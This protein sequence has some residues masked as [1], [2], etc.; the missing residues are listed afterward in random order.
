MSN[1]EASVGAKA[2]DNLGLNGVKC[3]IDGND[4]VYAKDWAVLLHNIQ[5][6]DDGMSEIIVNICEDYHR[7]YGCGIK[8]MLAMVYL[9]SHSAHNLIQQNVPLYCVIKLMREAIHDCIE[10]INT[11]TIPFKLI[12]SN[13]NLKVDSINGDNP[14][15]TPKEGTTYKDKSVA[16]KGDS[17]YV[18]LNEKAINEKE[19]KFLVKE[20]FEIQDGVGCNVSSDFLDVP[21]QFKTPSE[22]MQNVQNDRSEMKKFNDNEDI[23]NCKPVL[24]EM[25]TLK[26]QEELISD[27]EDISWFF[28]NS[29]NPLTSEGSCEI[30]ETHIEKMRK[31]SFYQ[32]DGNFSMLTSSGKCQYDS[33]FEDCFDDDDEEE[34]KEHGED[35]LDSCFNS[36]PESDIPTKYEILE[37]H[38]ISKS[39]K[40]FQIRALD[41]SLK[42][43]QS[44][45]N[46]EKNDDSIGNHLKTN[47]LEL[48]EEDK[49]TRNCS[50]EDQDKVDNPYIETQYNS[51]KTS[52]DMKRI[53][54]V[55]NL[56]METECN[57]SK[58]SSD[59]KRID[60]LLHGLSLRQPSSLK[61]AK[62]VL[63]SSR[64]FKTNGQLSLNYQPDAHTESAYNL[65][66]ESNQID[67][68][69][70][71]SSCHLKT[72]KANKKH[73]TK[74]I[75]DK[76]LNL[77]K[78]ND[79]PTN[80]S[81]ILEKQPCLE[82][83]QST[84][85]KKSQFVNMTFKP[86]EDEYK[87]TRAR[88]CIEALGRGLSR[89]SNMMK[90]AVDCLRKQISE[91]YKTFHTRLLNSCLLI[92]PNPDF[93]RLVNGLVLP[94][95][96]DDILLM[97]NNHPVRSLLLTGDLVYNQHHKGYKQNLKGII[98]TQSVA[99]ISQKDL[100]ISETISV[101]NKLSVNFLFVKGKSDVKLKDAL[102][103]QNIIIL[104][105]IPYKALEILSFTTLAI[106]LVYIH[107]ANEGNVCKN[108]NVLPYDES[109]LNSRHHSTTQFQ[110]TCP[111]YPVQTLVICHPCQLGCEVRE[112]EFWA[113]INRLYGAMNDSK[114][115][116]GGGRTEEKCYQFLQTKVKKAYEDIGDK[117]DEMTLF[118]PVVFEE[119]SN[120][121]KE[122]FKTVQHN[123]NMCSSSCHGDNLH[124][125][126][127]SLPE[128]QGGIDS[129]NI[130]FSDTF[131]STDNCHKN[132]KAY[133]IEPSKFLSMESSRPIENCV[134]NCVFDNFT[135]KVN[136]WKKVVE[137]IVDSI[138]TDAIIKT[139]AT[140]ENCDKFPSLQIHSINKTVL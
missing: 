100:W 74:N 89:G 120:V 116:P 25:K 8:T 46:I 66:E 13:S 58:T 119:I 132:Q 79:F 78:T 69:L 18:T 54:K 97:K 117:L 82:S 3:I 23:V 65:E 124:N 96:T 80:F 137:T 122:Y 113:C 76:D 138:R 121:F 12:N 6:Q 44:D 63:N 47:K 17:I 64:H 50:V 24:L 41:T 57:S 16:V 7:Q 68:L 77:K 70:S 43:S 123:Q 86:L 81:G 140:N 29:T 2:K 59:M 30:L 10:H 21:L 31:I 61:S 88:L 73:E 128:I 107:E 134:T 127:M 40:S 39:D 106:P 101:L 126:C 118:K 83:V 111:S 52:S 27:N 98:T 49:T 14:F 115:L 53:D 32:K 5:V 104:D 71:N 45:Q 103:T 125:T 38:N 136:C 84:P 11:T 15:V 92:G 130:N 75:L 109:Y 94:C 110:V 139:G 67:R 19:S 72:F 26:S 9:L 91:D 60:K 95:T 112:Q 37:T 105:S 129:T 48:F 4:V 28:E 133:Q 135:C 34:A 22:L 102:Q 90:Y 20:T 85:T 62:T 33:D 131:Q 35:E 114:I 51:S 87:D 108:I 56:N 93:T 55:D 99:K 42:N 36:A 1:L